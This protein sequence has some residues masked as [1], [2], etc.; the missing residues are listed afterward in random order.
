MGRVSWEGAG[1]GVLEGVSW[2]AVC[3]E[4]FI[5]RHLGGGALGRGALKAGRWCTGKGALGGVCWEAAGRGQGL[6][7]LSQLG[8]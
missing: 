8:C 1:R 5:R 4:G 3:W 6:C 2:E 7:L